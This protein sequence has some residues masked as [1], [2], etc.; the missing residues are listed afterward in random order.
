MS[1]PAPG[2]V[3]DWLAPERFAKYLKAAGGDSTRALTLYE[4][5]ARLAAALQ[6]DLGHLEVGLRNAYDRALLAHP[7]VAGRDWIDP[8]VYPML[9]PPHIVKD[10]DG[11]EQDKNA[12]PRSAIKNARKYAG[13]R[14]GGPVQRGKVIAEFMFGF[15]SYLSDSLH[16]KTLWV[17]TLHSAY[18][19]GADRAQLHAALGELREVRNRLAHNESIFDQTPERIRRRILF[20]AGSLSIDLRTHI[21]TNSE[22]PALLRSKP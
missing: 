2:W 8:A 7:T 21:E 11:N 4:W 3:V 17:A 19:P 14:E 1:A 5:N 16:E 9:L 20:V 13:Y 15:W 18:Q 12:T 6:R 22:A 10:Q